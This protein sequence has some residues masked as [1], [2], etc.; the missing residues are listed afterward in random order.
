MPAGSLS[1]KGP[2]SSR[3]QVFSIDLIGAIGLFIFILIASYWFELS[4]MSRIDSSVSLQRMTTMAF[5]ASNVLVMQGSQSGLASSPNVL[6]D[7][8][9]GSFFS[10]NY[11]LSK[12]RL[13]IRSPYE[14][15]VSL[16]DSDKRALMVFGLEPVNATNSFS[17]DRIVIYNNSLSV[18]RIEVWYE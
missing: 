5:V 3:G 17:V 14:L 18:L 6:S 10:S 13:A 2:D 12:Q 11:S 7:P 4:T 8:L 1:L 9:V 15:K 16:L